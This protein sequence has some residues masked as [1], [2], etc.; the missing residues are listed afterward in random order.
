MRLKGRVLVAGRVEGEALVS[1]QPLSFYGG[2]NPE[3]GVIVERGHMLRGVK[4]SGKILV[5]PHG[6]GS[7]VG[8]YVL[9]AMAKYGTAPKAVLNREAEPIVVV[10]CILAGIPLVDR[11]N[12]DPVEA[13][14]TGDK[15]RL[16]EDGRVEA[17]RTP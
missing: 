14:K 11:F 16:W 8:S 10:G 12:Q 5:F 2:I 4:V 9:Y 7:T 17:W 1:A 15:V 13:L 3:T 6:K